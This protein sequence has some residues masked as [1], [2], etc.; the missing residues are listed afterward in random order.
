MYWTPGSFSEGAGQCSNVQLT[1]RKY[2]SQAPLIV[3]QVAKI[4]TQFS[5]L[6]DG[7]IGGLISSLLTSELSI[8]CRVMKTETN[9]KPL[10]CI[11]FSFA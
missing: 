2:R 5:S 4:N 7:L 10:T 8:W 3:Q 9:N 1:L 11:T 6:N